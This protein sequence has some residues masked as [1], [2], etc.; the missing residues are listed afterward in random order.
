MGGK[1]PWCTLTGYTEMKNISHADPTHYSYF[2]PTGESVLAAIDA[3][4]RYVETE[5]P[6]D[7]VIGFSQGA[8]LAVMFMVSYAHLHPNAP[9]PFTCAIFLSRAATYDPV[10]WRCNG[11][12]RRLENMPSGHD[13]IPIPV[14]AIWGR[15]DLDY[16][17]EEGHL[18]PNVFLESLCEKVVHGGGHEVPGHHS[19][20]CLQITMKATRRVCARAQMLA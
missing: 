19:K 1:Q 10:S 3:L 15:H 17:Q 7:G 16:V 2:D 14:A 5:G 12:I 8:S 11:S 9:L 6:F 4:D 18:T 13:P 20:S